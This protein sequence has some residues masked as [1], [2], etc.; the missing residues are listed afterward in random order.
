MSRFYVGQ[1][2]RKVRHVPGGGSNNPVPVGSEGVIVA[3]RTILKGTESPLGPYTFDSDCVVA[4]GGDVRGSTTAILEPILPEGW[5]PVEWA[6]CLWQ[7][8]GI[9]A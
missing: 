4:Y 9:A 6:D 5:Q 1:R 3:L 7:P 2:V 8:E